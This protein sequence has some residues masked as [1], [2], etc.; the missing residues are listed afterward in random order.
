MDNNTAKEKP[1]NFILDKITLVFD[2]IYRVLLEYSKFVLLVLILIVSAQVFARY[3]VGHS[4]SWS[5][6]VALILM[7]WMAFIAMAIGV[8]MNLHIAIT[9]VFNA[10]PEKAQFIIG[11]FNQLVIFAIGV[12]LMVYGSLLIDSTITSTLPATHLPAATLYLM[13]PVS[14][15]YISY[16]TVFEFFGLQRYHHDEIL[17]GEK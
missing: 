12:V 7:V 1:K 13:I 14:G 2:A 15:F 16:F 17:G 10:L 4:I 6:E 8:R 3:I 9:A 11:K 5:D